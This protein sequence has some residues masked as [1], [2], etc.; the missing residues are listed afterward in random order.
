MAFVGLGGRMRILFW[1][2]CVHAMGRRRSCAVRVGRKCSGL[3]VCVH[4]ACAWPGRMLP[5][6][7]RRRAAQLCARASCLSASLRVLIVVVGFSLNK[8]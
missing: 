8:I 3:A 2:N 4:S 1:I 5:G 7:I 6:S